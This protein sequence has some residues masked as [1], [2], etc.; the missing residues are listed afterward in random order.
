ML[1]DTGEERGGARNRGGI[2]EENGENMAAVAWA[3]VAVVA[4]EVLVGGGYSEL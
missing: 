1:G 2:E 3:V 4:R